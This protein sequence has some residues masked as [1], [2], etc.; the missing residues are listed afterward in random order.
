MNYQRSN[1]RTLIIDNY[2]SFTYNIFQIM[3]E[4]NGSD[5][6]VVRN[7]SP[8]WRNSDV[9]AFDN[10]I[11]S[12]GPGSPDR[13]ADLGISSAVI[14]E[15]RRPLLGVCLGHQG[16]CYLYGGA[17]GPAPEV[18]HGRRSE[19]L[20]D[21]MDLFA[22]IPS[23][24]YAVRYHSLAVTTVPR[25]LELTAWTQGGVVMGVRHRYQP[26]WGVQFHPESIRTEHGIRLL[27]NF[28]QLTTAWQRAPSRPVV[29][30]A[31]AVAGSRKAAVPAVAKRKL[32]VLTD[33]MPLSAPAESIFQ[34]LFAESEYAFWLDSSRSDGSPGGFSFMGDA[35]GPLAR[36]MHADVASRS[37]TVRA[38]GQARVHSSGLFDWLEKDRSEMEV[39]APALPFGFGLGWVGYLGY[40]LKAETGGSRAH[41]SGNP[42]SAM[43]FADRALAL[44]HQNGKLYLLAL[45]ED[46][47]QESARTWFHAIRTQLAAVPKEGSGRTDHILTADISR[48][49]LR[50]DRQRYLELIDA[51]QEKINAGESYEICLTNTLTM[52]GAVD[53]WPAYR[54]LRRQNPAPFSAFLRLGDLS[55]LSAS[56]ER[57]IRV[58]GRGDIE[59][60]P[61]KGTR[62][63]SHDLADDLQMREDLKASEKDR[64]ENLMIVDLVRNDLGRIA[65]TGSVAVPKMFDI[66]SYATVHQL[67]STVRARLRPDVSVIECIR[68]AFPGGSMTGAPKIRTMQILDD[69]EQG[70]RGIY[71]GALG[72]ISLTGAADLSIVIRTIVVTPGR[73]SYGTGGAITAL[74]D[75]EAEFE[76]TLVKAA[77]M[78]RLLGLDIP[79]QVT[80][81]SGLRS[82][83][84]LR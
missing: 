39:E 81:L 9:D 35:S 36:V 24:F 10:V 32:R 58:S 28:S 13:I 49:S 83:A 54:I 42:D 63:R 30:S 21:G 31:G 14:L 47:Q 51:C 40:E 29:I 2:D 70:P 38:G 69:L 26:S 45:A 3:A 76:E 62:P 68:A 74:S 33:L 48:P 80:G 43:I 57:F 25:N 22:G 84:W 50:H 19:I 27:S 37:V 7:D 61:I 1:V 53:P 64:A 6:V 71:S 72:Y 5:P 79:D 12:P 34:S 60:K 20:H 17:V 52:Y 82:G 56:P 65:Q 8:G 78:F 18:Y 23:P 55:V 46:D 66:E 73:I 44:D 11:I 16:L 41:I 15:A 67:V 4:I 77:Q 59:A 75:P